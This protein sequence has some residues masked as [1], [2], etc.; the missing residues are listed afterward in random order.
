MLCVCRVL[1]FHFGTLGAYSVT[2]EKETDMKY[3]VRRSNETAKLMAELRAARK[4]L[5]AAR[6]DHSTSDA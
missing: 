1:F 6:R 3:V 4:E 5:R 2:I